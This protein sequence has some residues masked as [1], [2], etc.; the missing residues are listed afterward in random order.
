MSRLFAAR[1]FSDPIRVH[2]IR[3]RTPK[4]WFR[5]PDE[6]GW[7]EIQNGPF[8]GRGPTV[9]APRRASDKTAPFHFKRY[10][11]SRPLK[12]TT[13]AHGNLRARVSCWADRVLRRTAKI[14]KRYNARRTRSTTTR[15][16]RRARLSVVCV[17]RGTINIFACLVN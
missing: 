6:V 3:G 15:S 8:V 14:N 1:L 7:P 9:C 17:V 10:T 5:E 16:E 2:E 11:R 13:R 4:R 12:Y